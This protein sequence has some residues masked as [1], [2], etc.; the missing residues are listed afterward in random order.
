MIE[1]YKAWNKM[2]D[3]A[4]DGAIAP[5]NYCDDEFDYNEVSMS[6]MNNLKN[7]TDL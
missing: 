7:V 1:M 4:T 6:G 2:H 3:P 5:F